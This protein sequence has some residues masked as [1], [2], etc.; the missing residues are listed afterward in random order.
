MITALVLASSL[1]AVPSLVPTLDRPPRVIVEFTVTPAVY[2]AKST[3]SARA[4]LL[5]RFR[6][7]LHAAA[8]A[9]VVRHEYRATFSGAAVE[10]TGAQIA[11]IRRL[12]YVRAV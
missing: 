4:Q 7:D 12:P 5:A 8:P 11:A 10:A 9:A 1:A 6:A 3:L 2:A